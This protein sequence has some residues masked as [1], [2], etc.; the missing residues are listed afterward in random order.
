MKKSFMN[1]S[2]RYA[3]VA[4][5]ST[6]FVLTGCG[7]GYEPAKSKTSKT[8]A[9]A[10]KE[11]VDALKSESNTTPA[12]TLDISQKLELLPIY[13]NGFNTELLKDFAAY[14]SGEKSLNEMMAIIEAM[15]AKE[16]LSTRVT[17]Q[18]VIQ[19]IN[20]AQLLDTTILAGTVTI[21]DRIIDLSGAFNVMLAKKAKSQKNKELSVYV[22]GAAIGLV[23]G[24]VLE[25]AFITRVQSGLK[26]IFSK[27]G[28]KEVTETVEAVAPRVLGKE[29]RSAITP[30]VK[31][32]KISGATAA[33]SKQNKEFFIDLLGQATMT[34]QK[35]LGNVEVHF[36][37]EGTSI[38]NFTDLNNVQELDWALTHVEGVRQLNT[39]K[40]VVYEIAN[41]DKKIFVGFSDMGQEVTRLD[42]GTKD[43]YTLSQLL[44]QKNRP[45]KQYEALEIELTQ[46]EKGSSVLQN[47]LQATPAQ[48]QEIGK[49]IAMNKAR[50][51]ELTRGTEFTAEQTAQHAA[52]SAEV[53]RLKKVLTNKNLR[54]EAAEDAAAKLEAAETQMFALEDSLIELKGANLEEFTKLT[55]ENESLVDAITANNQTQIGVAVADASTNK[56]KTLKT[57]MEKILNEELSGPKYEALLSDIR[58]YALASAEGRLAGK[59]EL[60][61]KTA[62]QIQK[63]IAQD[64]RLVQ[65][66][67]ASEPHAPHTQGPKRKQGER[68]DKKL[69]AIA[70]NEDKVTALKTKL[71]GLD[72]DIKLMTD[73]DALI[74]KRAELKK[75]LT[76]V[77]AQDARN[78]LN[79]S[80][81]K[82]EQ[83]IKKATD[84]IVIRESEQAHKQ[85]AYLINQPFSETIVKSGQL[86]QDAVSIVLPGY[87]N[88]IATTLSRGQLMEAFPA[89]GN[90]LGFE[91]LMADLARRTK[92]RAKN[93][94]IATAASRG[95]FFG[96]VAGGAAD[97]LFIEDGWKN[98]TE[99]D[100][101]AL[102][103]D[104][105]QT[106]IPAA[107][108]GAT[109]SLPN[110]DFKVAN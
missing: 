58:T 3:L 64:D 13:A 93:I 107:S 72:A 68:D 46:V 99:S 48:S 24:T 90:Q 91:D 11:H 62:E 30:M 78:T 1:Q 83:D 25:P 2:L 55:K 19:Q 84:A 23:A 29:V 73:L 40:R 6:S 108:A 95:V 63:I 100:L 10:V 28:R 59:V 104:I 105:E 60:R 67:A 76:E 4:T 65:K 45:K 102:I 26:S 87:S 20:E 110:K 88:P 35:R 81:V 82:T 49:K 85:A 12:T 106:V 17:L 31:F 80:I 37:G 36:L 86:G 54:A 14:I 34:N 50:I 61:Q 39:G 53:T 77:V 5:L 9:T 43:T 56:I 103:K 21:K 109:N 51:A 8:K 69:K 96:I 52:L 22:G 42:R 44:T 89:I 7:K 16:F 47:T 57:Q 27:I 74:V 70:D 41:G 101:D 18:K 15:D 97:L 66:T 98:M 38:R 32:A 71:A 94:A 92:E 75:Q 79:A 33:H